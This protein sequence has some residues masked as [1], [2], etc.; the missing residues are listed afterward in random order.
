VAL[1]NVTVNDTSIS[2]GFCVYATD[3]PHN[4]TS[5]QCVFDTTPPDTYPPNIFVW[6]DAATNQFKPS[7]MD[8]KVN[9]VHYLGPDSVWFTNVS[10]NINPLIPISGHCTL[11]DITFKISVNDTNSQL[12]QACVTINALDCAHNF[13]DTTWCYDVTPDVNPPHITVTALSRTQF[14]V[15]VTDSMIE[16]RGIDSVF[17]SPT[18]INFAPF[19]TQ[20]LNGAPTWDTTV[21]VGTMGNSA[22]T[23]ITADDIWGVQ[24]KQPTVLASHTSSVEIHSWVQNAHMRLGNL[25][26]SIPAGGKV[27]SVPV[28]FDKTTALDTISRDR[29]NIKQYQFTMQLSQDVSLIPFSGVNQTNTLSPAATWTVTSTPNGVNSYV[30]TGTSSGAPLQV[31][32]GNDTLLWL[33]F[34]AVSDPS[35]HELVVGLAPDTT[36]ST[37]TYNNNQSEVLNGTN[38]VA[39]LPAPYGNLSGT[40][41]VVAGT[42]APHTAVDTIPLKTSIDPAHPNPFTQQVTLSYTVA[43]E[44][45]VS[46]VIYDAVGR[47]VSRLVTQTQKPGYYQTTFNAVG[48]PPGTYFARLE[49]AGTVQTRPMVLTN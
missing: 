18:G 32:P 4:V 13:H 30:I 2:S 10:S 5:Q 39:T 37:I 1:V 24:S 42:C 3:I 12:A 23:T 20:V 31:V 41:I 22:V 35:T 48:L 45:I 21:N 38:A 9:D 26:D 29:K 47:E 27:V 49:S 33:N 8:V 19:P 6:P 7:V 46:L 36:A 34:N 15:H 14:H 17:L 28:I 16:D 40:T 11:N 44:S 25:F 43:T